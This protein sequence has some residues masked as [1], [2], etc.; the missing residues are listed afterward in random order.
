MI[1]A[2]VYRNLNKG[3]LSIK[4]KID[5]K[6]RV[7]DYAAQAILKNCTFRTSDKERER[8]A[9]G[10]NKSVHAWIEG[11]L[12]STDA[13]DYEK[14]DAPIPYYNPHKTRFFEIDGA[15]VK[16]ADI[17]KIYSSPKKGLKK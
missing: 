9:A 15:I 17:C 6:W 11:D 8:I 2:R 1:R 12:I 10:G 13:S 3:G 5:G 4:S 14:S 16:S 7:T